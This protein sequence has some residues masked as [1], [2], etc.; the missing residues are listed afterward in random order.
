MSL[1][2]WLDEMDRMLVL[3]EQEEA[4]MNLLEDRITKYVKKQ[5]AEIYE[6]ELMTMESKGFTKLNDRIW[7]HVNSIVTEVDVIVHKNQI[8][9]VP[10][11]WDIHDDRLW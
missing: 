3:V 4:K 7:R 10:K 8:G 9:Y 6:A 11:S 5:I 2:E 1:N